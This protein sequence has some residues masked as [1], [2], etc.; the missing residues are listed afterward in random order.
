M[1]KLSIDINSDLG[2]GIGND[3]LL[4]PYISS[5]SIACGGHFGND[6]S[7]RETICLAK[8]HQVRV[9]AHPSFP[10][11]E[12]FGRTVLVISSERL[13]ET[14]YNQI[15]NLQTI[16]L[17]EGI[18]MQH[19]KLHGALYNETCTNTEVAEAAIKAILETKLK[20]S[21]FAPFNAEITKLAHKVLPVIHEAFIDRRY[22][23]NLRL[24][25]RTSP[26]AL[27]YNP[28]VA[29]NQLYGMVYSQEVRT[30]SNKI[31][32]IIAETFCVH[33]DTSNAMQI[34]EYIHQQFDKNKCDE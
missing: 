1:K 11:T 4:M 2:E 26:D 7:M 18:T 31:K 3:H 10:D 25:S 23:N 28:E 32:P 15:M 21:L 8:K 16:C 14:I 33:G 19:V 6:V 13:S 17:E 22:N 9:G 34:L 29:F 12:N 27:I 30:I 24:V 5:C 20:V